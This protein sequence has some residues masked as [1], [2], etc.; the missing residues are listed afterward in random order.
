LTSDLTENRIYMDYK[1]SQILIGKDESNA[2][3]HRA[4]FTVKDPSKLDEVIAKVK[5]LSLKDISNTRLSIF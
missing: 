2:I 3:V 4:I 1:T 5:E